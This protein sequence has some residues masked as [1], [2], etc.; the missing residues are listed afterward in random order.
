[1]KFESITIKDIAR[2]LGVST[3]TVSRALRDS[4]EIGV[5]TKKK[6]LEYSEKMNYKP[7]QAALS[8]KERS[9]K[10]IGIVISEVA[11][12][13]FSQ[14]IDGIESIAY[15]KGY[16]VIITQTHER[17]AR[18]IANVIHLASRSVDGILISLSSE[19]FDVSY[20]KNFH[21]KKMPI[22]FFD[23]VSKDIETHKVVCDNHQGAYDAVNHLIKSG[24]ERIAFLGSSEHLSNT[25]ER[26]AGYT[27]ALEH[28]GLVQNSSHVGFCFH[29]G[30]IQEE[31]DL[32]IKNILNSKPQAILICGDNLTANSL[33]YLKKHKVKIP[34]DIAVI[35][36]T[37]QDFAELLNPSLTT[38]YQ[39]AFKIGGYATELLLQLIESKSEVKKFEYKKFPCELYKRDSVSLKLPRELENIEIPRAA[40]VIN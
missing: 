32:I 7:N 13:F 11:N 30:L 27:E 21:E 8:L 40:I 4:S 22:V 12:T 33:R 38:V 20:L 24:Y 23:R 36:F 16:N 31:L 10:S 34:D 26:F 39:P 35:G 2:A 37:N 3:S 25:Q 9:S 17:N 18:E 29:G 28:A 15:D 5:E 19:T 14:A 1:M 6:V